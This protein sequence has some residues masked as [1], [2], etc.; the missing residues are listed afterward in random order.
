MKT[1]SHVLIGHIVSD[2]VKAQFG[3]VLDERNFVRGNVLPDRRITFLTRPHFLKYNAGLV[4]R[5]IYRLLNNKIDGGAV[6]GQISKRLGILC[7]YYTDFFCFAHSPRFKGGLAAHRSYEERLHHYLTAH[8]SELGGPLPAAPDCNGPDAKTVYARFGSLHDGY[9]QA[10]CSFENDL[11]YSIYAC[12]EVI[13]TLIFSAENAN[14]QPGAVYA[15][16]AA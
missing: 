4:Q 7:H 1:E 15:L 3:I 10:A 13:V 11:A 6:G 16:H 8:L 12:A 5:K 14:A 2:Y 9:T